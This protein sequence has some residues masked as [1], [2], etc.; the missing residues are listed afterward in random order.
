MFAAPAIAPYARSCGAT[1]PLTRIAG[2]SAPATLQACE[3]TSTA[4]VDAETDAR[5]P[6][7]SPEPEAAAISS[8]RS[9]AATTRSFALAADTQVVA[10]SPREH[11][12]G[13]HRSS[14]LDTRAPEGRDPSAYRGHPRTRV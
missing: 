4:A 11:H 5:P 1:C 2:T 9:T 3:T 13:G 7:K 14:Q 10:C 8:P 12:H 6:T